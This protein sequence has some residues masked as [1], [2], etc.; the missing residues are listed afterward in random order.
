MSLLPDR[1]SLELLRFNLVSQVINGSLLDYFCPSS[2]GSNVSVTGL[3][4]VKGYGGLRLGPLR[5]R[6]F[7]VV[8]YAVRCAPRLLTSSSARPL[9]VVSFHEL[10]CSLFIVL[11]SHFVGSL[12]S[13]RRMYGPV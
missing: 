8:G 11:K 7:Q 10:G 12:S 4:E 13:I 2:T 5:F 6:W 3:S 9:R 1:S